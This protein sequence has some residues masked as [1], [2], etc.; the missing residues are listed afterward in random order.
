MAK[1]YKLTVVIDEAALKRAVGHG[2]GMQEVLGRKVNTITGRANALGMSFRT[3]RYYDRTTEELRGNTQPKY[4]GS[5][6][7]GKYG[8]VGL[9][10]PANYAAMKDTH[11][12]NT[13]LK[14]KRG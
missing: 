10:H 7:L 12:H 4:A 5:V 14:A 13:L 1:R 8:W 3:G 6:Q 2:D 9:V 11:L